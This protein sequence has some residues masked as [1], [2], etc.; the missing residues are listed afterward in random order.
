MAT[1]KQL[2]LLSAVLNHQLSRTCGYALSV[3]A[4]NQDYES[5]SCSLFARGQQSFEPLWYHGIKLQRLC[6][7]RL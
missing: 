2:L 1:L 5:F 3:L 4:A 6:K 7:K